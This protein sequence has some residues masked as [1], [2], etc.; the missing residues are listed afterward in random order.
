MATATGASLR[1]LMHRMD[2]S[3]RAALIDQH[4]TEQR[5]RAIAQDLS[6]QIERERDRARKAKHRS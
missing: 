4:A 3:T 6:D 1:D 5:D 2:Q